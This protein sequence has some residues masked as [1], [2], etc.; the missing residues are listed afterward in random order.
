MD[1]ELTG[2]RELGRKFTVDVASPSQCKRV[3]SIKIPEEDLVA[4][5]DRIA[6]KLRREIKVPGF[7]KGKVPVQYVKKYHG[8]AVEN[9]AVQNLLSEAYQKAVLSKGL[10]PLAEPRFENL[11][12]EEGKGISVDAAIEVRP[13]VEIKDYKKVP[14][15]AEKPEVKDSE[16]DDALK[17]LSERMATFQSVDR[18]AASSDFLIIDYAPL[19]DSG[20]PVEDERQKNHPV[21]LSGDN[22]VPEFRAGLTGM[23]PGEEKE[24]RVKYPEDFANKSL[25]GVEKTFT[26]KV[27]EV[28]EK[29]VP[30]IDDAFA[31]RFGDDVNSLA[32]LKAKVFNDLSK[33]AEERYRHDVTE[34]IIDK[35]IENNEFEV[36][37]IMI[38]NYLLSV[39]DEDRRRRPGVPDEEQRE[40]E[41]R[42]LFSEAAVRTIRKYIIMDYVG[43]KEKLAVSQEEIDERVKTIADSTGKPID[44]VKRV[45]LAGE[46]RKSL[47]NELLDQKILNFLRENADIK[48]A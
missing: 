35:I 10:H 6:E 26:V 42:E 41:I 2:S 13:D 47:E 17:T 32:E 24:L 48:V 25:A 36:P 27:M 34:K 30:E 38:E 8:E 12:A 15:E 14:V 22:I 1:E 39:I 18:E 3:L 11:Q 28:K 37:D 33:E 4:E 19:S 20:E 45:F 43:K 46:G 40:K 21:D 23:K 7:R 29:L 16:V 9:E 44:E 5:R 31:Q